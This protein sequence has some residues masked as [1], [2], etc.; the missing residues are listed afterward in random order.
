MPPF[1]RSKMIPTISAQG[2][3]LLQASWLQERVLK[4]SFR[5]ALI[6]LPTGSEPVGPG[7]ASI[8]QK[9]ETD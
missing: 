3:D 1:G 2:S 4:G 6:L 5:T 9:V 8:P 7:L